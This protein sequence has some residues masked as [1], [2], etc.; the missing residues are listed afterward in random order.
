MKN[1]PW[2]NAPAV[3]LAVLFACAAVARPAT[4]GI[5]EMGEDIAT[6]IILDPADFLYDIQLTNEDRTPL[7]VNK[8][9]S[10]GFNVFPNLLPFTELG[11]D[12][13]ARLHRE[14]GGWPQID[15]RFG[16]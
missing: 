13:K 8:F 6:Q 1:R 11:L 12:G 10:L 2:I 4:A 7:P 3:W 15:L 9:M 14:H 16:G 5:K